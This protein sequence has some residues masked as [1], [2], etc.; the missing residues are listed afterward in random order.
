[1]RNWWREIAD[2]VGG[3][4]E[5]DCILDEEGTGERDCRFSGEAVGE[6]NCRFSGR[7]WERVIGDLLGGSGGE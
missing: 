5:I 2:L 3:V 1:M 6:R 7:Q 4:W